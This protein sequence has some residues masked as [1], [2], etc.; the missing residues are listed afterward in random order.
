MG[1]I[2]FAWEFG[3]GLGHIQRITPLARKM[4]E[5]GHDVTCIMKYVPAAENVLG[6]YGIDVIQAPVFWQVNVNAL[7]NTF[8]YA[9]NLFNLGYTIGDGL[10]SMV[11]AWRNLFNFMK[12]E[13]T[14]IDHAPTAL[15]AL[16]TMPSRAV[17]YGTGYASPPK[18]SPMP[19]LIPWIKAPE[20]LLESSEDKARQT[21][22]KA[23]SQL[24]APPLQK[25]ADLFTVQDDILTTFRELDHYQNREPA[26][27]WGPVISPADGVSPVWPPKF[28]KKIFCYLKPDNP[29][30]ESLL[31]ALKRTAAASIIYAPGIESETVQEMQND[32]LNFVQEPIAMQKVCKECDLVIC[33]AGHGTVSSTLLYGKPLLVIPGHNHLEQVLTARNVVRLKAGLA[34]LK[35]ADEVRMADGYKGAIKRLLNE[36]QFHQQAAGFAEKYK[37]FDPDTQMGQIADRCEEIMHEK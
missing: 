7:P 18:Q 30:F 13:L 25:L 21:I 19:S 8:N 23:L 6:R 20:G 12:P 9:L 11:K 33:H 16:R 5:R 4:Q 34:I 15:I 36:Q 22:N 35:Q 28:D 37:T 14:V 27:Y 1:R 17:L 24:D 3:G 26:K 29:H 10:I 2:V 31:Y 32:N